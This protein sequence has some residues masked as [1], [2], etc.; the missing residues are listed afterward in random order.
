[1]TFLSIN[2]LKHARLIFQI[3]HTKEMLVHLNKFLLF[4]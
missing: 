1:M 2:I 3:K 4:I